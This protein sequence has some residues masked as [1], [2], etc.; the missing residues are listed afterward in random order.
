MNIHNNNFIGST[1]I[2]PIE[3]IINNSILL[4]SNNLINY[5]NNTSNNI[6]NYI[7]QLDNYDDTIT[8]NI[9][10]NYRQ[11]VNGNNSNALIFADN[12]I[13][14][15]IKN[16]V[17]ENRINSSGYFEILLKYDPSVDSFKYALIQQTY[18]ENG[19]WK[20]IREQ[21]MEDLW[22]QLQDQI[23]AFTDTAFKLFDGAGIKSFGLALANGV[24]T[25]VGGMVGGAVVALATADGIDFANSSNSERMYLNYLLSAMIDC[26]N[27]NSN[28]IRLTSNYAVETSNILSNRI[29]STSNSI[30]GHINTEISNVYDFI[31]DIWIKD[32]INNSIYNDTRIV[33]IGTSV[34]PTNTRLNVLGNVVFQDELRVKQKCG[35]GTSVIQAD[36]FLDVKGDVLFEDNLHV[37]TKISTNII[38][39]TNYIQTQTNLIVGNK[40][41]INRASVHPYYYLDIQGGIKGFGSNYFENP[42]SLTDLP[43]LNNILAKTDIRL[44]FESDRFG[45]GVLKEIVSG[46][47][48][49]Y[50]NIYYDSGK[51]LWVGNVNDPNDTGYLL[52]YGNDM[53]VNPTDLF[54][55]NQPMSISFLLYK[56][57]SYAQEVYGN[58]PFYSTIIWEGGYKNFTN[59]KRRIRIVL[60]RVLDL[61]VYF[62]D[63]IIQYNQTNNDYPNDNAWADMC[64]ASLDDNSLNAFMTA[65]FYT[66]N[67]GAVYVDNGVY[68]STA[69]IYINGI[70]GDSRIFTVPNSW[71]FKI[72]KMAFSKSAGYSPIDTLNNKKYRF[73]YVFSHKNKN[74]TANEALLLYK[75]IA[76]K[77]E[78]TIRAIGSVRCTALHADTIFQDGKPVLW[79]DLTQNIITTSNLLQAQIDLKEPLINLGT[80]QY[81]LINDTNGKVAVNN[82][83][84]KA[85]LDTL[86]NINTNFTIQEQIDSKLNKAGHTINRVLITNTNGEIVVSPDISDSELGYLDGTTFNINT[87]NTNTSN[88]IA[89]L[90]DN[91][92][93]KSSTTTNAVM[94][95]D[96]SGNIIPSTT[97]S[98]TELGYLD[99][100]TFNINTNNTNT[101]NWI[102]FLRDNKQ[103]NVIAG[104][105]LSFNGSTLN[106]VWTLNNTDIY[107]N[108]TGN[109][110]I[111]TNTPVEELHIHKSTATTQVGIILTDNTTTAGTSAV[112]RGIAILKDG[113]NPDMILRNNEV[114]RN[115]IF[116]TVATGGTAGTVSEKVRIDGSGNVGIGTNV[117][118]S[119]LTILSQVV[120]RSTYNHSL[121]PCTITNQTATSTTV[122]NDPQ[123][124]LN[125][126]RQGTASQSFGARCTLSLCRY[127]NSGTNSRSRLDFDLAHDTY[128]DVVKP[129][130]IQSSGQVGIGTTLPASQLHIHRNGTATA[131]QIRMTDG[132]TGT[133]TTDGCLLEKDTNQHF[134]IWNNE[135]SDIYFGINTT[136]H[137]RI[138]PLGSIGVGTTDPQSKIHLYQSTAGS[139][140]RILFTDAGTGGVSANNR[141]TGIFK[142][143]THNANLVNYELNKDI[144]F[145]TAPVSAGTLAERMRI[146][147]S[148]GR[149]AI[150]QTTANYMLDVAGDI[151][152]T[153]IVRQNGVELR[154]LWTP[155]IDTWIKS[156]DANLTN[157]FY[158]QTNNRT[159]FGSANGYEWRSST[160]TNILQLANDGNIY[161]VNNIYLPTNGPFNFGWNGSGSGLGRANVATNYSL[162]AGASDIVLRGLDGTTLRQVIIQSG[163]GYT[164]FLIDTNN[165]VRANHVRG[166]NGNLGLSSTWNL[167]GDQ[168]Q[169]NTN[170]LNYQQNNDANWEVS[171]DKRIKE[172]I[173]IAD[174]DICYSNIQ[175]LDLH[176]FTYSSNFRVLQDKNQIGFIAQ[177][178]NELFPKSINYSSCELLNGE[179]IPDLMSI[180]TTQINYSLYGA[181]RKLMN[182]V[183]SQNERIQNLE[184]IIFNYNSN[185]F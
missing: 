171:S 147:G 101:S 169:L 158:F 69:S 181:V 91:K 49:N 32:D 74:L 35:I 131:I 59:D 118:P 112:N 41:A 150:N 45:N 64:W 38:E 21:F 144:I 176:R 127:E 39:T 168:I 114:G 146:I 70:L 182:I 90:R 17:I 174:Y 124:V 110:G 67:F 104:T 9:L 141:G 78:H 26:I 36:K 117:I 122:L 84:T 157:R 159:Y 72:N 125:L 30:S 62:N 1:G 155:A 15:Q 148:S 18:G 175:K 42:Q 85:E 111:G 143:T 10:Y 24:M 173:T 33:G 60:T 46:N 105:G 34:I 99:G 177:E 113:T 83:I 55:D 107:N 7:N 170:G 135:A 142:D 184:N 145:S 136:E 66:F 52:Y 121:A 29:T 50:N 44:N 120:D 128:N 160:D 180:S 80:T 16:D 75:F 65:R 12:K 20:P 3:E 164:N 130:S 81:A 51:S 154:T 115:I 162:S 23:D 28:N 89:F 92:L 172:N 77:F 14:F 48:I 123:P 94:I 87:N 63:V 47:T 183:E 40:V 93:D 57:V 126:C 108:N 185:I 163:S 76:D 102:A 152:A 96:A 61:G 134:K 97:I 165:R 138:R 106:S 132:T 82:L 25:I 116:S 37:N 109:V 119:K 6:I 153:G 133:N 43:T 137:I 5:T 56:S 58:Q 86:N 103:G 149:L 11:V 4:S 27:N 151:N 156:S 71:V 167:N 13:E 31:D 88:W 179:I 140:V 22:R 161:P 98:T 178:V 79:T 54:V 53:I 139:Q 166:L 100:T 19:V 73:A 68:K 129:I 8:S 2:Y 95:T